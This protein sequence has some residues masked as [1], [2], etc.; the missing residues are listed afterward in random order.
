[1]LKCIWLAELQYNSISK[2]KRRVRDNGWPV[3]PVRVLWIIVFIPLPCPLCACCCPPLSHSG[4]NRSCHWCAGTAV[5]RAVVR[6]SSWTLLC[7][8]PCESSTRNYNSCLKPPCLNFPATA[9]K[10]KMCFTN[11]TFTHVSLLFYQCFSLIKW[12]HVVLM[13]YLCDTTN[14]CQNQYITSQKYN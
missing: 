13:A 6:R 7:F 9:N 8:I 2:H 4:S 11:T 3:S 12:V 1:L 10:I 5:C 14:L